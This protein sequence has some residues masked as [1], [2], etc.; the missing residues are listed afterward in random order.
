MRLSAVRKR[1]ADLQLLLP[2]IGDEDKAGGT[3]QMAQYLEE[4]CI[5]EQQIDEL[6]RLV[7]SGG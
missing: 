2:E 5:L 4:Q 6:Q 1:R 7:I 3:R